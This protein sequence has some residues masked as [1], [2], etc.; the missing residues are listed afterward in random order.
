MGNLYLSILNV[1]PLTFRHGNSS[2]NFVSRGK[3]LG[4]QLGSDGHEVKIGL[5]QI[6]K[7]KIIA[8]LEIGFQ[9]VGVKSIF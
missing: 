9:S 4:W 3:P 2:N 8:N 6:Y 1:D 5:N 7:H